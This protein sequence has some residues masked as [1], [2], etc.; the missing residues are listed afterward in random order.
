MTAVISDSPREARGPTSSLERPAERTTALGREA[1]AQVVAN[2]LRRA[3]QGAGGVVLV[4]G[5]PGIG[6][7]LLLRDSVDAAA[8]LGFSLATATADHAGAAIPFF[9]LRTAL[10]EPF[11]TWSDDEPKRH[12]PDSAAWLVRART[13]LARRA[14]IAPVLVALDD[15]DRASAD[16]IAALRTLPVD[17]GHSPIVWLL[18]RSSGSVPGCTSAI[19]PSRIICA[20]HS[21][22]SASRPGWNSP[23]SWSS[24]PRRTRAPRRRDVLSAHAKVTDNNSYLARYAVRN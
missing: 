8:E 9:A 2:L 15:L 21:A 10:R 23:A 11:A 22:S 17:L 7:T 4:E 24:G 14:A 16:T 13:L 6:K 5:E 18:A 19:T 20:R 3:Q 12:Q 1:Q